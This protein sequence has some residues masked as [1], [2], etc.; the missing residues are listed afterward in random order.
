MYGKSIP[1]PVPEICA[2]TPSNN[3][4]VAFPRIFGPI[5]LKMVDAAANSMT[6]RM[7]SL[8]GARYWTS[9]ARVPLKSRAFSPPIIPIGPPIGPP[10]PMGP[11]LG[12]FWLRVLDCVVMIIPQCSTGTWQSR[13]KSDRTSSVRHG[14]QFPRPCRHPAR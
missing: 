9:L 13:G 14:C 2:I 12:W 5:M 1:V 11:R 8:Y 4:V 10:C 6:T 3:L 7:G